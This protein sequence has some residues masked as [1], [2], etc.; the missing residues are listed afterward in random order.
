MDI[1]PTDG[2]ASNIEV[3]Q[4]DPVAS[5]HCNREV[6]SRAQDNDD[7]LNS[8]KG[9]H[10]AD[11]PCQQLMLAEG[12]ITDDIVSPLAEITDYSSPVLLYSYADSG[13]NFSSSSLTKKSVH[14]RPD[15]YLP[16]KNRI[17]LI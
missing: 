7:G 16:E 15:L 17:L 12:L 1:D 11:I 3:E 9:K 14:A 5:S 6:E 13:I 10:P 4:S 2:Q 8:P